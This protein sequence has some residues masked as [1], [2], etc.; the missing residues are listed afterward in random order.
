MFNHRSNHRRAARHALPLVL[1]LAIAGCSGG[2]GGAS[3]PTAPSAGPVSVLSTQWGDLQVQ[4]NGYAVDLDRA[5]ASIAVG[6]EKGRR[7]MG[8]DIDRIWL[9]G[10]RITV[11]PSDW[12]LNGQHVRES[13]E[14]R[15]RAG[16][17]NVLEH[18]VQHVFAWELGRYSDCRT[19]QDHAG[20]YDLH[21]GRLP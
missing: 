19:Y 6:Y 16:F 1:V 8:P 7:Q 5:R 17:E 11:M 20:G 21:C 9:S 18:E 4:A 14:L 2:S 15:I 13:R 10:Y 12:G 3:S